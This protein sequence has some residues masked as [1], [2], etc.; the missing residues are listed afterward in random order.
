LNFALVLYLLRKSVKCILSAPLFSKAHEDSKK[1]GVSKSSHSTLLLKLIF[2]PELDTQTGTT[3]TRIAGWSITAYLIRV[4]VTGILTI[5]LVEK[6]RMTVQI[7]QFTDCQDPRDAAPVQG[8][9]ETRLADLNRMAAEIFRAL[10]IDTAAV[11]NGPPD[12]N[13]RDH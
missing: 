5:L 7:I 4:A 2:N 6:L 10:M 1:V 9:I 12:E 11:E 13:P 3:P 8:D